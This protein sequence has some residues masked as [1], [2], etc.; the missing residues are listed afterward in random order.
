MNRSSV[1]LNF[2]QNIDHNLGQDA[3]FYIA[4]LQ[5]EREDGSIERAVRCVLGYQETGDQVRSRFSV[6]AGHYI[7]ARVAQYGLDG[8]DVFPRFAAA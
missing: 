5:V 2:C 8:I 3:I 6:W 4:K 7:A 1:L